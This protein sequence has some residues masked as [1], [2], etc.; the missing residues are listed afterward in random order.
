MLVK[1]NFNLNAW[2]KDL[3]IEAATEEDAIAQL[4]GMSVADIIESEATIDS[5][6][7]V[8]DIDTEVVEYD[9]VVRATDI[10]YD[11]GSRDMDPAVVEYLK[12]LLS[13][14]LTI[15]L[16]GIT[17]DT[18]IETT[19]KDEISDIAN[20]DVKSLKFQVIEKK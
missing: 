9:L 12:A 11:F 7:K 6:I 16:K 3:R 2:V 18:D 17:D 8:S 5:E 15:T 14:E 13:K 1:L 19:L 20:Y 10:E 4:K